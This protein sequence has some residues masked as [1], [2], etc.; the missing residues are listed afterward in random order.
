MD[1]SE[2]E[3]SA[4]AAVVHFWQVGRWTVTLSMPRVVA[5]AVVCAVAEWSPALPGRPLTASEQRQYDAG[6]A[7]AMQS[8]AKGAR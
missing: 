5:G 8:A 1:R 7:E 6:L 4:E 2:R 3:M